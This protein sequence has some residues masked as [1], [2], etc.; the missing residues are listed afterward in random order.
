VAA[1]V[2]LVSVVL[3]PDECAAAVAGCGGGAQR[4]RGGVGSGARPRAAE[5]ACATE[6]GLV[7]FRVAT[8]RM[9]EAAL[10]L[11][12]SLDSLTRSTWMREGPR[13][14]QV[15]QEVVEAGG[16]G[17]F[18]ATT[19]NIARF[20]HTWQQRIREEKKRANLA[21]QRGI[22]LLSCSSYDELSDLD[23]R[24]WR[25]VLDADGTVRALCPRC[26]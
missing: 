3:L 19:E 5:A 21:K 15:A 4:Y 26:S 11:D 20:S 7:K 18:Q 22:H 6:L 17:W 25:L 8:G 12:E 10:P 1:P 2:Y 13:P 9:R 24:G 16:D 14:D 23:A